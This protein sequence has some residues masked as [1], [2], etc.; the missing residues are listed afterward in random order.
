MLLLN[1]R[2]CILGVFVGHVREAKDTSTPVTK[3]KKSWLW[4]PVSFSL[5]S[6]QLT[7]A[8]HGNPGPGYGAD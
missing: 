6:L 3:A 5:R 2:G 1:P 4:K 7:P 8:S